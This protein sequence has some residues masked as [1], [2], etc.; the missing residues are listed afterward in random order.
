MDKQ[1]IYYISIPFFNFSD[2]SCNEK[3]IMIHFYNYLKLL[4][5]ASV[6]ISCTRLSKK[7]FI[8]TM[9]MPSE[10]DW[11]WLVLIQTCTYILH[12]TAA[13]IFHPWCSWCS[14]LSK[15]HWSIIWII[16][17]QTTVTIK[18]MKCMKELFYHMVFLFNLFVPFGPF[19][20]G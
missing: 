16:R 4:Y 1:F 9:L 13:F 12:Q 15:N 19:K 20:Y 2:V 3:R 6:G 10:Y 7:V 18:S 5:V 8:Q 17:D 11:H 14:S